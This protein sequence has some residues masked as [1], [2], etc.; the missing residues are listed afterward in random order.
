MSTFV[1]VNAVHLLLLVLMNG[2]SHKCTVQLGQIDDQHKHVFPEQFQ[3]P[4][5]DIAHIFCK[6]VG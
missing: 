1:T 3:R 5:V 6:V 4:N 2:S